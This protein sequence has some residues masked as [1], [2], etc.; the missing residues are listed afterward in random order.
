MAL[1]EFFIVS[2]NAYSHKPVLMA[3]NGKI[4][5]NEAVKG[6]QS[7][8]D[9]LNKFIAECALGNVKVTR[10]THANFKKSFPSPV[11]NSGPKKRKEVISDAE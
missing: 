5:F 3:E 1:Y 8:E 10:I 9:G 2:K 6:A 7:L 11:K 4:P